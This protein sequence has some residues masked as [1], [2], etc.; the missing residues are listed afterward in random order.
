MRTINFKK[1]PEKLKSEGL[2]FGGVFNIS[3]SY[4]Q[5]CLLFQDPQYLSSVFHKS[6]SFVFIYLLNLVALFCLEI[7]N[8]KGF[9]DGLM[10]FFY[11]ILTAHTTNLFIF[12]FWFRDIG[13]NIIITFFL[14]LSFIMVLG[15]FLG[16]FFWEIFSWMYLKSPRFRRLIELLKEFYCT[17]F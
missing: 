2:I 11:L 3:V 4:V 13:Q 8:E 17:F 14:F 6:Y 9:F 1:I 16:Y 15:G 5:I 12:P 10:A 7:M